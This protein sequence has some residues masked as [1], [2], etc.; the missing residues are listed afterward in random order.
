MAVRYLD[1]KLD[2]LGRIGCILTV[3]GSII[4]VMHAPT[5]TEVDSLYDFASKI[6]TLGTKMY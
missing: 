1:E 4:I 3:F 5:E 6:L 2:T